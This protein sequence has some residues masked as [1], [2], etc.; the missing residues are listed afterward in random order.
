[1]E[2]LRRGRVHRGGTDGRGVADASP[3][4]NTADLSSFH[5]RATP[6]VSH[7]ASL[8]L[9]KVAVRPLLRE[10]ENTEGDQ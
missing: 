8:Y 4:S 3:D 9:L 5:P 7:G 2:E 10:A 1:M 6:D